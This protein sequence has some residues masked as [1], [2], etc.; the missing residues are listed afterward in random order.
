[1]LHTRMRTLIF[2]LS[3]LFTRDGYSY[4]ALY[5]DYHYEYFYETIRFC[6]RGRDIVSCV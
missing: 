2:I 1:M 3:E 5:F 4:N 6:R